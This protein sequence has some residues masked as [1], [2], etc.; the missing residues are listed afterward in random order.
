ML[1]GANYNPTNQNIRKH[2]D[3]PHTQWIEEVR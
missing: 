3:G 1:Y 2:K